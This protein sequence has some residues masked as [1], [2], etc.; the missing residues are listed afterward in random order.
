MQLPE[1]DLLKPEPV[2][3]FDCLLAQILRATIPIPCT[4]TRSPQ[5]AL[6]CK[7]H[8][9]IRVKR[10]ADELLGDIWSIRIGGVDKIG[11]PRR[12]SVGTMP[13]RRGGSPFAQRNSLP[14]I[15]SPSATT[16]GWSRNLTRALTF[17]QS[18]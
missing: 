14:A 7:E 2:P 6:S 17:R 5:P 13:A 18:R 1:P 16:A 9:V 4:G 11:G 12:W 3:A 10:L 8:A 15:L